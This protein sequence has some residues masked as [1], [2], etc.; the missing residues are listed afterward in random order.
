MDERSARDIEKRIEKIL[1]EMGIKEPPLILEDVLD[2]LN[3]HRDY[4]SLN[5]PKL[6]QEIF[7][8]LRIGARKFNSLMEKIDLKGLL[9]PD[10]KKILIERELPDIKKRWVTAHEIG[11]QL[12]PWHIDF[13]GDTAE[14]LDPDYHEILE[15]E[16]NYAAAS[17]LFLSARFST[18]ASDFALN[19]ESV[20]SLSKIYGN[21]QAMTLRRF[22]QHGKDKAMLAVISKPYWKHET[23]ENLCRYF[24]PSRKFLANFSKVTTNETLEQIKKYTLKKSGGPIGGGEFIFMDDNGSPHEFIGDSFFNSYDI[25]T[26]IVHKRAYPTQSAGN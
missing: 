2:F 26:L 1:H 9:L 22:V 13:F 18:E 19:F 6:L 3:I 21:S 8:K 15:N 16:A 24:I 11:H 25:L 10:Q 7:H 23:D 12:I 20:Q 5:D 14:T 17:L 4:Y